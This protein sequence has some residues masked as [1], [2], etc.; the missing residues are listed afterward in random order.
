[1]LEVV[2]VLVAACIGEGDLLPEVLELVVVS[3]ALEFT[4]VA[5]VLALAALLV[6]DWLGAH[7]FGAAAKLL[8]LVCCVVPELLSRPT[9]IGACLN[10]S[11]F[12]GLYH[13][14]L[15]LERVHD[16]LHRRLGDVQTDRWHSLWLSQCPGLS[17]YNLRPVGLHI[18][19]S[20]SQASLSFVFDDDLALW[21]IVFDLIIITLY[22]SRICQLL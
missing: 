10:S 2:D 17:I 9:F 21:Y 22:L 5:E 18:N 3:D 13:R 19:L 14:E 20:S 8:P 6:G 12:H 15:E 7:V 1:M 4:H 16:P 11:S